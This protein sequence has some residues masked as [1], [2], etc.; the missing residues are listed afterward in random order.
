MLKFMKRKFES[1]GVNFDKIPRALRKKRKDKS[2]KFNPQK[3]GKLLAALLHP[4]D[5]SFRN[6]PL[7]RS[8]RHP[9]S[10]GKWNR[11]KIHNYGKKRWEEKMGR[12]DV[13]KRCEEKVSHT[14]ASQWGCTLSAGGRKAKKGRGLPT[15]GNQNRGWWK[16]HWRPESEISAGRAPRSRKSGSSTG[17]IAFPAFPRR[18]LTCWHWE[19]KRSKKCFEKIENDIFQKFRVNY[20]EFLTW[21][22]SK[23]ISRWW[24]NDQKILINF[25][26]WT[27]LN[28]VWILERNMLSPRFRNYEEDIENFRQT[29]SVWKEINSKESCRMCL[30]QS[31]HLVM[32][33]HAQWSRSGL[34]LA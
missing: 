25:L 23:N 4:T 21:K 3:A 2:R 19:S 20:F 31:S 6:G 14:M 22:F 9:M 11:K 17:S 30:E 1:L 7:S 18:L 34:I 29:T 28:W 13:K 26:N 27:E 12:R 16:R 32:S 10:Y 8:W 33:N 15:P 5:D 24:K